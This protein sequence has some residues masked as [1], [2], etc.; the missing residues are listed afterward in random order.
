M[1]LL[2]IAVAAVFLISLGMVLWKVWESFS[3][4]SEADDEFDREIA[5]LNHSQANRYSEKRIAQKLD[6]DASWQIMVRRGKASKR[7]RPPDN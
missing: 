4:R 6:P 1:T 5:R 3:N 2:L 7:R